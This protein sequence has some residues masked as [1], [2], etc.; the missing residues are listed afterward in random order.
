V[1]PDQGLTCHDLPD[2]TAHFG[3]NFRA[4]LTCKPFC[5]ILKETLDD[6]MLKVLLV[7]AAFSI[8]FDMILA[9]PEEREHAWIEGTAIFV[10]VMVVAGVGS[11]VDFKKEKAFVDSRLKSDSKNVCNVLRN[12]EVN[13]T[14]HNN[15]HV[16][17]IIM[18][19]Y[20]MGIPVD[21]ILLF[22]SQLL[23]DESAM[24]GESDEIK[25]EP[26]AKCMRI[27][28][29]KEAD[30]NKTTVAKISRK[31][32]VPSPLMMS[33]TSVSQGEGK[34]MCIMVGDCSCL[35]EI[36]KKLKVRPE[37]TPLQHKLEKIATDIG[38]MGT[39]T[40]ILT[41]H[42]LLVRFFIEGYI[43][44]TVDI[45]SKDDSLVVFLKQIVHYVII[46]VAII[47]VAIPEGLPLAVMI[48]LAYSIERMLKDHN[49]VK[50]LA[51]C[52]IM[53]GASNI[54]SDKTGTLTLNQ[55]KVTNIYVG[56][57]IKIDVTQDEVTKKMTPL[58]WNKD[59]F[60]AQTDIFKP[61]IEQNVACNSGADPGPTD[62]SMV[63]LLERCKTDAVGI[64]KLHAPQTA[65]KFPFTSKRKRMST[66]LENV[67][68][69]D[70]SYKKR[71]M[72]KG[73][74]EI[75]KNC[76]SHYLDAEGQS[77]EMNDSMKGELD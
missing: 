67:E 52:E 57:D 26:Q 45:F 16:G 14:H 8:T 44:R 59:I 21:G 4:P 27:K 48:S 76:C 54:C 77:K 12:G 66:I 32:D 55:M 39:Y 36:I 51:S 2:R 13:S 61:L 9:E 72:V 40:A 7:C 49:D 37:V 17:D 23:C 71:I 62:K 3:D 70:P 28:H 1:D 60:G 43:S 22:S 29:E 10:A 31:H 50:R 34:M 75:V 58:D 47:V 42:V 63:D 24:T 74:S 56:R 68:G 38:L 46:G 33:G 35:G 19:Q 69:A 65:Q 5:T 15:L 6:F 11:V 73:A 18:V 64:K 30:M 25:K 20:G 41:V 53:G